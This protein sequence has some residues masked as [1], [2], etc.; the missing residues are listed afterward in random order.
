[1]APKRTI[2]AELDQHVQI[3]SDGRRV[4]IWVCRRGYDVEDPYMGDSFT[5]KHEW[6]NLYDNNVTLTI[7]HAFARHVHERRSYYLGAVWK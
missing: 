7:T 2:R 4:E 5:A 3:L 6:N 1:M